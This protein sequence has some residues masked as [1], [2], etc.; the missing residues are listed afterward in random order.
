MTYID[1]INNILIS[2]ISGIGLLFSTEKLTVEVNLFTVI[3]IL[4]SAIFFS[5]GVYSLFRDFPNIK[6]K[7]NSR[8]KK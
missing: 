1:Y 6:I 4:I 8:I 2:I 5:Y 7:M 3:L